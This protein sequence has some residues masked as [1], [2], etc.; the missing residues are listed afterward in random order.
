MTDI[1]QRNLPSISEDKLLTL[2]KAIKPMIRSSEDNQLYFSM[3]TDILKTSYSFANKPAKKAH[4]MKKIMTFETR[5]NCG[6]H[7]FF[8]PS[9]AEVLAQMAEKISPEIIAQITAFEVVFKKDILQQDRLSAETYDPIENQHIAQ[10]VLYT[11]KLPQEIKAQPVILNG[12][13]HLCAQRVAKKVNAVKHDTRH[14]GRDGRN[15]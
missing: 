2:A 7:L 11:G 12:V 3:P 4:G 9:V 5:H 10:T 1:T 15:S 8:K 6:Y 13:T 14:L